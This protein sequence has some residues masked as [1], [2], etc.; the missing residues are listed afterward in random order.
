MRD[1]RTIELVRA[2]WVIVQQIMAGHT[3][4]LDCFPAGTLLLSDRYQFVPV[5]KLLVGQKI[6]GRDRWSEVRE[7]AFR[8]HRKLD[9]V[10][11]NNGSRLSLTP[12]HKVYV[13]ECGKHKGTPCG[14]HCKRDGD[15]N[16]FIRIPLSELEVGMYILT[17]DRIPYGVIEQDPRRALIEG[18]Y[19]SD[20][21]HQKSAFAISGQDGCPKE[22]Q[23][24]K[25]QELCRELGVNTT[26]YRK[27]IHIRD[28]EWAL[29]VQLMGSRAPEKHAL[30]IGLFEEAARALLEG[31]MADSGANTHGD[32]RT[33][34]T[35]SRELFL[36][37]R[38]LYKMQG[39]PCSERFVVHHGGLGIHPVWRLGV[40]QTNRKDGRAAKALQVK[41]IERGMIE[42]PVWDIQTDDHYV[43]L[44]EADATVS[45]CDDMS[46]ILCAL[47]AVSGAECRV[48]TVAFKHMF[49]NGKRQYSHVFAQVREPRTGN[50]ITLDP[51]AGDKTEEMKSRVVAAKFWPIA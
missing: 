33:F 36:Q 49:F 37:T 41:S 15:L 34:T 10:F 16:H 29:R 39:V 44:P 25:V 6:W 1:P 38:I 50:W 31:I 24:R 46:A 23:K 48:V 40:R 42:A 2:P 20:G 45:N 17:P 3:P 32:G 11:L 8:G 13:R 26:W 12:E 14:K 5:E 47:A 28:S 7:I 9:T 4:G 18:L 43:Y 22:E 21:W 19:L 27:S 30:E 51:V 35:T